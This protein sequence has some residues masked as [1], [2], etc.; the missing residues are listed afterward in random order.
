MCE[1][2]VYSVV[3]L[4]LFRNKKA[5]TAC[6]FKS[7]SPP[8]AAA[9][10]VQIHYS[11][12]PPVGTMGIY[13]P[14][15]P[16]VCSLCVYSNLSTRSGAAPLRSLPLGDTDAPALIVGGAPEKGASALPG[17]RRRSDSISRR[18][19]MKRRRRRYDPPL[20]PRPPCM[21]PRG[22]S[23]LSASC[24]RRSLRSSPLD[25]RSCRRFRQNLQDVK[26]FCRFGKRRSFFFFSGGGGGGRLME[27]TD[28]S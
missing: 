16:V 3:V 11:S 21:Q 19:K 24:S 28:A 27:E 12:S 9:P 15:P 25:L 10:S 7:F 26:S 14:H 17:R 4:F 23:S 1:V 22:A 13:H 6:F 5:R 18:R 20:A 8:P 2:C